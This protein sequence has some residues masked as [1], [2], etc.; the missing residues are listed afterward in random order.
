MIAERYGEFSD[1]G[2]VVHKFHNTE[3]CVFH[4]IHRTARIFVRFDVTLSTCGKCLT[5]RRVAVVGDLVAG[6]TVRDQTGR[7]WNSGIMFDT[8][9][10]TRI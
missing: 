8:P 3:S 7:L 2:E 9:S 4:S 5:G 10:Y 1:S 6:L